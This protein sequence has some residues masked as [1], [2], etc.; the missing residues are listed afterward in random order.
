MIRV[1]FRMYRFR[2]RCRALSCASITCFAGC[3]DV[4]LQVP[5]QLVGMLPVQV[6]LIG[7]AVKA[8]RN[9]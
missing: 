1:L 4:V 2:T 9:C 6:D 8:E 3:L 7:S 5:P